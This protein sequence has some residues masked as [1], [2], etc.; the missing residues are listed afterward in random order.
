MGIL[1]IIIDITD[2]K[3]AEKSLKYSQSRLK[4]VISAKDKF[5]NIMAHDLKNPF[6]A[7]LGLT[8]LIANDFGNQS[9][10][11]LKQY[12]GLINN[13]STHIY[14]LLENLLEWA[15][16]QSG[17]I[18]KNPTTFLLNEIIL[19]CINLF[20]HS[21]EQKNIKLI[22]DTLHEIEVFADKNMI[23]TILRNLLSNAVKFTNKGGTIKIEITKSIN[24]IRI[25]V[26]D[27]GVGILAENQ[28]KLFRIDQPVSTPGVEK[29]KGTGLGLIICQEFIKQ[30]GGSLEVSSEPNNG[31]NF[32]FTIPT[33][34]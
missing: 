11:E 17:S 12:I 14:S 7:V 25:S 16:A 24:L 20:K 8:S 30:N 31:S 33:E 13:S 32:S 10:A 28:E 15:R 27:D 3:D 23:M 34:S 5:F 26:I 19:E 9:E 29:E 21:I 22:S 18:E 6:N 1:G 2:I 4:E